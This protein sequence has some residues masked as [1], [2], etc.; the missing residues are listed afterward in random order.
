MR[1]SFIWRALLKEEIDTLICLEIVIQS[2]LLLDQKM[3]CLNLTD[4]LIILKEMNRR[5]VEGEFL[6]I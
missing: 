4:I 1:N 6:F 5:D 3:T 2:L